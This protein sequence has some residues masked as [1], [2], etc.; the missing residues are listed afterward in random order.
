MSVPAPATPTE[1]ALHADVAPLSA[2]HRLPCSP[3]EAEAAAW[4]AAQMRESGARVT[5][6]EED[7]HGTY[8]TPLGVLNGLAAAG[9]LAVL[10]GRRGLGGIAGAAAVAGLWQDLTGGPH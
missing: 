2:L 5:V 3:G 9:G 8:Y 7:V 1:I 4:I 6:D 10:A